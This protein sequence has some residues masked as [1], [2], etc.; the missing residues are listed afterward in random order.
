[1]SKHV[2]THHPGSLDP[3][4]TSDSAG[5]LAGATR[6]PGED[7]T[8]SAA[9]P[10]L[11]IRGETSLDSVSIR[12]DG[13]PRAAFTDWLNVTYPAQ[14]GEPGAFFETFS[15]ATRAGFGGMRERR[16]RGLH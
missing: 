9:S 7:G 15:K 10:R 3:A 1:M 13:N 12:I 2:G 11:V 5:A 16:G 4:N 8:A 6:S 14:D